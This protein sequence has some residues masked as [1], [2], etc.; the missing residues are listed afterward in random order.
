MRPRRSAHVA[1][2]ASRG[3]TRPCSR[4]TPVRAGLDAAR[5]G[6][7]ASER[8]GPAEHLAY[9]IYTSG[10]TG[11]PKGVAIAARARLVNLVRLAHRAY[12]LGAGR[13]DARSS[14][15]PGFDVV[16]LGDLA[17]ARAR[18]ARSC[19]P[20]RGDARGR[21][22]RSRQGSSTRGVDGAFRAP[23][24]ARAQSRRLAER[25]RAAARCASVIARAARRSTGGDRLVR[26]PRRGSALAAASTTTARRRRTVGDRARAS[27]RPGRGRG[28]R[29]PS[30]GPIAERAGVR[31]RRRIAAGADRASP[32]ELYVGGAGLARGYLGR[33]D[34]T[35]ERF[36]PRPVRRGPGRASTGP[37]T[38]CAGSPTASSSS[39]AAL[40]HQVKVRGF[41]DRARRDRGRARGAPRRARGG[42]AG[43]RGRAR[44][45]S[46]S[47]PT[48]C[49]PTRRAARA[50]RRCGRFLK[51][52]LPE[53]MVPSAFVML[54]RAAADAERQGRPAGAARAR[55]VGAS[56]EHV[57]PRGPGRGGRL[58]H[59]RR[60]AAA[61]PG[62]ARTT[63]SSS[64]AGTRS[65]RRRAVSRIR[66]TFGV[67][68]P[69]A[70]ALRGA[71]RGRARGAH[72]GR[73]ARGRGRRGAA[74]RARA[75]RRRAGALVRAG[76]ALVPGAARSGRRVVPR[77]AGAAPRAARSTARRSRARSTRS[78]GATRCCAP[79]FATMDGRAAAIR[80]RRLP[81]R[82]AG[83]RACRRCPR[84]SARPRCGDAIAAEAAPPL[85]PLGRRRRSARSSSRS[86]T[87]T[88]CSSWR[89]TTSSPT[90]G[91]WASCAASSPRSTTPS[92]RAGPRRCRSCRS[93]T[94]TTPRGSA[95][96]LDGRGARAAARLLEGAARRARPP[97]S[98]CRPIARGP[99][100]LSHRGA[101]RALRARA[102]RSRGAL[103]RP[104]APRGRDALHDAARGVRRAALP[105]HGPARPRR[106]HAHRGPHARRDGGPHRLLRQH[107]GAA[108]RDLRRRAASAS[109]SRACARRA[110]AP[111]RTRTCPSSGWW[112]SSHPARDLSRTPLFQVML[113]LQN[114]PRERSAP[115]G[116]DVARRGRGQRRR[117]SS[118]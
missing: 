56:G 73:A 4:S 75:A 107:P 8:V 23:T 117:R 17:A 14:R 21:A 47:W 70:R 98:S 114:A 26:A 38:R 27:W 59:L 36:V 66:A 25:L 113:A 90:A 32:G 81:A 102:R 103:A 85:R 12:A 71:H 105:L 31:A 78:C 87:R 94:P 99:P 69:A 40:D 72:R 77:A 101:A 60:G 67:E 96:W 11:K 76:A 108:R 115:A 43:A 89:C 22:P 16:G 97:R 52:R 37:A 109:C 74:P 95:R 116:L 2:E 65:W 62:W 41:R 19:H 106:R 58:R 61:A 35:A 92:A 33:P 28:P 54:E 18:A 55:G 7:R 112:R 45:T 100:V 9:V 5:R 63:A 13:S 80:G 91:R 6:R 34:L 3:T 20:G 30:G 42:G 104:R 88:T 51:E 86:A 44:A 49:R 82:A 68:L 15:T 111:T 24:H 39:S 64:S 84:R 50:R 10:S 93:S 57:A 79:R 29:P 1:A 83:G 118:T 53:Y 110:S 48:W 46:G